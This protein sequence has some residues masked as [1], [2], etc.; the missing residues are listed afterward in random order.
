MSKKN[1]ALSKP[2]TVHVDELPPDVAARVMEQI[3]KAPALTE[4]VAIIATSPEPD[5]IHVEATEAIIRED[6]GLIDRSREYTAYKRLNVLDDESLAENV[7][8]SARAA[9]DWL[10][11]CVILRQRFFDKPRGNE[12]YGC[13]SWTDF[14]TKH[15]PQY[16]YRRIAQML[17]KTLLNPA[18]D[19]FDSTKTRYE[20]KLN[21][22][23][24][25][26]MWLKAYLADGPKI[27]PFAHDGWT[28]PGS[29]QGCPV[30]WNSK[31]MKQAQQNLGIQTIDCGRKNGGKKM[32]LPHQIPADTKVPR[33]TTEAP[34]EE[35]SDEA[36]Q[37]LDAIIAT[38]KYPGASVKIAPFR[39]YKIDWVAHQNELINKGYIIDTGAHYK[40]IV[41][42]EA[43]R[44]S[45]PE[46]VLAPDLHDYIHNFLTQEEADRLFEVCRALPSKRLLNPRNPNVKIR[47][48]QMPFFSVLPE[49]RGSDNEITN[50]WATPIDDAPL[51][52]KAL[53]E[54][55]SAWAGKDINYLS[56]VGYENE[57]DH[58]LWHQHREDDGGDA[59]VYDIS[60][61]AV[62]TFG[63]RVKDSKDETLIHAAHGSL[64]VIPASYNMTHEH[65]ILDDK[66]TRGLRISINCKHI[67][68]EI[69]DEHFARKNRNRNAQSQRITAEREAAP[70]IFDCHAGKKYPADAV[71]V[72]RLTR[73]HGGKIL[74]PDTPFGNHN[75]HAIETPEGRAAWEQD[76]AEL[77]KSPE[78]RAQLEALRGKDLLCWCK[79]PN[80]NC[81]ARTWLELANKP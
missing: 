5:S 31:T 57:L 27:M 29:I 30:K 23:D 47:R 59:A 11:A 20:N 64:I 25:T 32:F 44:E 46:S 1:K 62:R 22:L 55:L 8:I 45:A 52:I 26:I 71:Y 3:N 2:G 77:M 15:I 4:E 36:K 21:R 41:T 39:N 79:Q 33:A 72:G 19:K 51:E 12:I 43:P 69:L 7:A 18:S 34:R 78:F 63:L 9:T 74:R 58:I 73:S 68:P 48:L 50:P 37:M 24:E 49:L 17:E 67:L 38:E 13:T 53:R 10:I 54:K 76:V 66:G 28:R 35:L 42:K 70:Q 16:S 60:L 75:K 81:H 56:C 14:C 61:G 80:P 65:T 40:R 6:E